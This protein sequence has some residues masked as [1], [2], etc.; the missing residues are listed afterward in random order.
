MTLRVS[1]SWYISNKGLPKNK[2]PQLESTSSH[3]SIS[4]TSITPCWQKKPDPCAP[5]FIHY[6]H[7]KKGPSV[8]TS[9][10]KRQSPELLFSMEMTKQSL[11]PLL[12]SGPHPWSSSSIYRKWY[13]SCFPKRSQDHANTPPPIPLCC[14]SKP[15]EPRGPES[16]SPTTPHAQSTAL[17]RQA[18][19]VRV[20]SSDPSTKP[21]VLFK[22]S[23]HSESRSTHP[24][25]TWW[26]AKMQ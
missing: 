18:Q 19:E 15:R 16:S 3:L 11:R 10:N 8:S 21:R 7:R 2:I 1:N 5:A 13:L 6:V 14:H 25:S 26:T 23:R 9:M 17:P 24:E 22:G 12:K 20:Q 4:A